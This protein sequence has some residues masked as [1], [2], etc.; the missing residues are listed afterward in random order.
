MK[1]TLFWT[2]S[3]RPLTRTLQNP[4]SRQGLLD[5]PSKRVK[6][7][8]S[9]GGVLLD[10]CAYPILDQFWVRTECTPGPPNV[11]KMALNRPKVV[12]NRVRFGGLGKKI[13]ENTPKI[14][15]FGPLFGPPLE[16]TPK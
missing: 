9:P 16:A 13:E 3:E 1:N 11:E 4:L 2:Y 15:L 8:S 14:P 7:G 5:G 12:Q 6:L 10:L